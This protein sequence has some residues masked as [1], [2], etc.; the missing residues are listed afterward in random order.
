METKYKG[1][2]L[3]GTVQFEA[4]GKPPWTGICHCPSCRR[5]TGGVLGGV[6]GYP[7]TSVKLKGESLRYYV[8]SPGVRRSFCNQC[9]SSISY[10]SENW[11]E[12]IHIMIGVFDHSELLSPGFHIFTQ[13]QLSWIKFD[14]C[15]TRYITTPGSGET[16]ENR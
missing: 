4:K 8:S 7:K 1:R 6:C 2:C 3:C 14:D 15:R 11:P 10:E 9:G 13:Y 12:D 16:N 5:A